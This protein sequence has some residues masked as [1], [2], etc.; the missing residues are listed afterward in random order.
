MAMNLCVEQIAFSSSDIDESINKYRIVGHDAWVRD[1]V[2][3]VHLFG[4]PNYQIR[5][6]ESFKV[7]L[8]FN[9]ELIEGIETELITLVEGTTVQ[10]LPRPDMQPGALSHLGYHVPDN[11][12]NDALQF[13]LWQWRHERG[14]PVVQVSQTIAHTGTP[15]RYRYAFVDARPLFGGYLKLIQRMTEPSNDETLRAGTEAYA[16]LRS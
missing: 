6:G 8:A 13:A 3:A 15:R 10:L 7:H 4:D 12:P 16:W 14:C 11:D 2:T 9:Y 1:T 5:A